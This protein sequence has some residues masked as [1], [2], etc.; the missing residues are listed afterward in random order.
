MLRV[1]ISSQFRNRYGF[2]TT[3]VVTYYEQDENLVFEKFEKQLE[4]VIE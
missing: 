4:T 1:V 3:I 2:F